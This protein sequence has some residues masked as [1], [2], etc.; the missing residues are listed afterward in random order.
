MVPRVPAPER[1]AM[2]D[3]PTRTPPNSSWLRELSDNTSVATPRIS[4][5]VLCCELM[6]MLFR[7]HFEALMYI[8]EAIR[9]RLPISNDWMEQLK[10]YT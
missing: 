8:E 4:M 2:I 7:V 3:G 10:A 5:G 1:Y 6:E 9:E